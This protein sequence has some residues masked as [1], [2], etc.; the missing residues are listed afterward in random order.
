MALPRRVPPLRGT[1]AIRQAEGNGGGGS[2]MPEIRDIPLSLIDKP[3]TVLGFDE[4]YEDIDDLIADIRKN[5]LIYPI[6]VEA[7]GDRYRVRDGLRRWHACHRVPLFNVRCI[8]HGEGDPP[9]EEVKLKGNLL[10]KDNTDAEIAAWLGELAT[11]HKR[12]LEEICQM[13]GRSEEWVNSR[14]DLLRGD[15]EV[16]MA[17]A[18]R[19]INFSQARVLNRCK[20]PDWRAMGLHYAVADNLPARKLEEYFIRNCS[21]PQVQVQQQPAPTNGETPV[22]AAEPGIVCWHCGGFRDPQNMVNI[23]L[24]RWELDLLARVLKDGGQPNA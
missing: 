23:W 12:S 10:R 4:R 11:T 18:R 22:A 17:L 3:E 16:L 8:V 6:I 2:V 7:N 9:A 19:E 13:V 21:A 15:P 24:H 20:D 5:G 14:V 1:P